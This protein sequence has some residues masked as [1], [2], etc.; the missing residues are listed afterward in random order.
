[1]CFVKLANTTTTPPHIYIGT[2]FFL[3][4]IEK[5]RRDE[6][7]GNYDVEMPGTEMSKNCFTFSPTEGFS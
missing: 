2:V 7:A 4:G 6:T 3:N 5:A 1:M